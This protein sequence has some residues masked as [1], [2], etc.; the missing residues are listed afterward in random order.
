MI[1][2][3]VMSCR[4]LKRGLEYLMFAHML[5]TARAWGCSVMLGEYLPSQKNG[6]VSGLLPELGFCLLESSGETCEGGMRYTY[7]LKK[8]FS[9]AYYIQEEAWN[10]K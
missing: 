2:T 9:V 4:V 3:W 6:M 7:D 8:E 5:E 10:G 1:D